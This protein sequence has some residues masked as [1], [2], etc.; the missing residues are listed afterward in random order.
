MSEHV[1]DKAKEQFKESL[2]LF[3]ESAQSVIYYC[4]KREKYIK[5]I[6]RE[7]KR[8]RSVYIEIQQT[9]KDAIHSLDVGEKV[10]GLEYGVKMINDV[11][12]GD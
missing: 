4:K 9:L 10:Q 7:N 12:G 8:Y 11:L 1:L 5:K 2:N 6:E 3:S